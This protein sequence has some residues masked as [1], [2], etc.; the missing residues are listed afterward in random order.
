LE[1]LLQYLHGT[2]AT[3]NPETFDPSTC[4]TAGYCE[5]HD[6]VVV[7]VVFVIMIIPIAFRMPAMLMFI[8]PSMTGVPAAFPRFV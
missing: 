2:T 1:G 7:A 8:P 3:A 6:S 5:E 4:Q